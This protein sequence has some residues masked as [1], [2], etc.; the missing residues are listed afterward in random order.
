[1]HICFKV[2]GQLV[3][4]EKYFASNNFAEEESTNKEL[5]VPWIF[6]LPLSILFEE[7]QLILYR[8]QEAIWN[9]RLFL[10]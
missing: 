4:F 2:L 5:G 7:D 9:L 1:M 10:C 6:D 3:W 8:K